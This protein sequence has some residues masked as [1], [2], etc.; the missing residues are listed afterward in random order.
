MW[1]AGPRKGP[2]A[3]R[4][5]GAQHVEGKWLIFIDDDCLP[6]ADF[7]EAYCSYFK[8]NPSLQA[9]EGVIYPD[10]PQRSL[11]EGCP[12]NIDGKCFWS[13]N[14]AFLRKTFER[15]GGFD[16]DYPYPAYEDMDLYL[17]V[18]KQG[19]AIAFV[20]AARV[21]HPW[22]R[23]PI[24]K[25]FWQQ[26]RST[27][28]YLDKHPEEVKGFTGWVAFKIAVGR[29][30]QDTI[31]RGVAFRGRGMFGALAFDGLDLLFSLFLGARNIFRRF[32]L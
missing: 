6:D 25:R 24:W 14:I 12:Q 1:I 9:A 7:L 5:A 22:R 17:R 20:K 29:M 4:N 28:I 2:A 30:T 32:G 11:G 3:N 27:L 31:P 19:I 18:R 23:L 13:C 21:C 8:D 15:L 26:R 10:R 16:P